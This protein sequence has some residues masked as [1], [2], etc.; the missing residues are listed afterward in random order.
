LFEVSVL[1]GIFRPRLV[2]ALVISVFMVAIGTGAL[3]AVWVG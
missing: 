3:F 2:V 1:V